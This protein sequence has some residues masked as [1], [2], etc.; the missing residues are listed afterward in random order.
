M[1]TESAIWSTFKAANQQFASA[2]GWGNA[3]G[4]AQLYKYRIALEKLPTHPVS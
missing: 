4:I 2:F 3:A 1:A